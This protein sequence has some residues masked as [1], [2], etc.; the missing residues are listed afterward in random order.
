[1]LETLFIFYFWYYSWRKNEKIIKYFQFP[2]IHKFMNF[3][4]ISIWVKIYRNE[5][6]EKEKFN[7]FKLSSLVFTPS[8]DTLEV[9]LKL[10]FEMGK[11]LSNWFP[12]ALLMILLQNIRWLMLH[13][14]AFKIQKWFKE[15]IYNLSPLEHTRTTLLGL[16]VTFK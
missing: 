16:G 1:M 10:K 11:N 5:Y 6:K 14:M 4:S 9:C 2:F 3:P 13:Y 12:R 7:Y 15:I 8:I